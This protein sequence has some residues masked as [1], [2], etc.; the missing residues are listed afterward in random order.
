MRRPRGDVPPSGVASSPTSRRRLIL[1]ATISVLGIL[2]ML[3]IATVLGPAHLVAGDGH[4]VFAAGRSLAYDGDLDLTNQY[5]VMGDRWGLGRDPT[6]DRWRL[7][8]REIGS[9]ILMI[10]GLWL[11]LTIG[12]KAAWEPA[13][14]C[15]GAAASL[16][17]CGLGC[18]RTLEAA[19]FQMSRGR[20]E[21][22]ASVAV[23]GFVV[24]FYAVGSSGYPHALDAAIG[25][26]LTWA[27]VARKPAPVIGALLACAVLTRMQNV[28]WLLW[29]IAELIVRREPAELRRVGVIAAVGATG[30][31]PQ[32]WLGLAH[33]GSER[34][35]LGW[36]LAFFNLD[37][38]P[39]DLWRVLFGVH[40][41]VLWTP[42]AALALI[43][44]ALHRRAAAW[45]V[46]V[47]LWLLLASVRDV[48]GGDAFGAR[49]LSGIVG[50][51]ALGLGQL[52][53]VTRRRGALTVVLASLLAINLALTGLAI[54]G[55][56]SLASPESVRGPR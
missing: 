25:A 20:V 29:P 35:A 41:L 49:R 15:L 21:W 12:A 27:L 45:A 34:G 26:W 18:V 11:H 40:G 36:T 52:D 37:G 14:A 46:L 7:P 10:P 31:L 44:L 50:L 22:L 54:A 4:Y 24:P 28:L 17:P 9:S 13:F 5:W 8:P 16:G 42:I 43:G 30:L 1:A 2:A 32:L 23:F 55:K 3:A 39:G 38:Y 53:A 56:I 6:T 19:G 33:P 51:L 47:G 48:D